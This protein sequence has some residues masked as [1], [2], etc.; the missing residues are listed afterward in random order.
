M[1]ADLPD[2]PG[3]EVLTPAAAVG[4][5]AAINVD[6]PVSLPPFPASAMDGWAVHSSACLGPP[7]Y[8]FRIV[9]LASAGHPF[10]GSTPPD[11]CVRI[12]SGGAVP[13]ALDAVVIQEDCTRDGDHILAN[14]PVLP[15][16]NVRAIGHDV[17]AGDRLLSAGA[18]IGPFESA[19]LS[20]CG[21]TAVTVRARPRVALF[22]TGDELIEPGAA[23]APGQI[24]DSNRQALRAL[25]A[26]LPIELVDLGVIP[27]RAAD[28]ASAFDKAANTAAFIITSGGV[29]VGDADLVKA[30]V[31]ARGA[32]TLWRLNLKPGKPL[33]YGRVGEAR[34]LGLPG[35][36]VSTVVT[37]LLLARPL[38]LQLAGATP[39]PPLALRARV[40]DDIRHRPGREEFQRGTLQIDDG[41]ATVRVTG[42]QSSNRLA[43]FAEANCLIRIP[44][45][46]GNVAAGEAM[47]VLPF[48]GLLGPAR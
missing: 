8:R 30:A 4:R 37:A 40:L 38:L 25:L 22:S 1:L 46:W 41:L 6:A 2:L 20:A 23:L 28:I 35:N 15:A 11:G 32:L 31:S 27:D 47:D 3:T 29:S 18:L 13:D 36:P 16:D 7:P 14:V 5:V 44:K 48:R 26:D 19:W 17:R 33:A 10:T 34:F 43:S 42:D 45:D 21:V 12:F 39:K 9:G 24:Y